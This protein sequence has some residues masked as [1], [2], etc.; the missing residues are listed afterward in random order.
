MV[1]TCENAAI[2]RGAMQCG[3]HIKLD[4]RSVEDEK[5]SKNRK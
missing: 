3:T 4:Y 5:D 1:K 2:G